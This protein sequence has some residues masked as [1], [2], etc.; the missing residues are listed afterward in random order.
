M[1]MFTQN[2]IEQ[3]RGSRPRVYYFFSLKTFNECLRN[4]ASQGL[5]EQFHPTKRKILDLSLMKI[6]GPSSSQQQTLA[7]D[8]LEVVEGTKEDLFRAVAAESLKEGYTVNVTE[9]SS[10]MAGASADDDFNYLKFQCDFLSS[11]PFYLLFQDIKLQGGSDKHRFEM[12]SSKK[13]HSHQ[14]QKSDF[15][16]QGAVSQVQ[17]ILAQKCKII[18]SQI[19]NERQKAEQMQQTK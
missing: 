4:T 7:L 15:E 12:F 11:C 6:G 18:L 19:T 3:F 8:Q 2:S 17:A 10:V 14:L 16:D 5:A 9:D 13:E 1:I